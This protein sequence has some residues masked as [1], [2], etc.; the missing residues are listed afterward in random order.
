MTGH[1]RSI[2]LLSPP[3]FEVIELVLS[4]GQ[5]LDLPGHVSRSL[6][7]NMTIVTVLDIDGQLGQRT[8][9]AIS[10]DR[11]AE[12]QWSRVHASLHLPQVCLNLLLNSSGV[13]FTRPCICQ[14]LRSSVGLLTAKKP[15]Q[16]GASGYV[17]TKQP[18]Y[19]RE[20]RCVGRCVEDT[21]SLEW[22][23]LLL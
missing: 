21:G 6:P 11:E 23:V 4:S 15:T 16:Q 8:L 5:Y 12:F 20:G 3:G 1:S 17:E 13:A 18:T 14:C 2:Q 22:R 19:P 9:K 10:V 7:L